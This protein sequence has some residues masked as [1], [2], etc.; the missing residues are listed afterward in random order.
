MSRGKVRIMANPASRN[1]E[2]GMDVLNLQENVEFRQRKHRTR[3]VVCEVQ[4]MQR[5]AHIFATNPRQI[6]HELA[7]ISMQLC[8]ADSAGISLEESAPT[9]GTQF[10]WIATVGAYERLLGSVLPSDFSPCGTCLRHSQPQLI[11]VSKLFFDIIQVDAPPITDG[12]LIPWTTGETRGTIWVLAH[13]AWPLFDAEDFRILQGLADFAA[14][15]IRHQ[16]QQ[17]QLSLQ[18][19]STA[20][21]AMANDLAHRINNPLQSLMNTI[22]LASEGGAD[23]DVFARQAADDLLKLSALVNELLHLPKST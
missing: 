10:R 1:V 20:A 4:A 7:E 14:I 23:S 22:F 2:N 19:A 18:A 21:A 17:Q 6:V 15:A 5:L 9:G 3:D 11:R 8:G 12:L 16:A 13:T